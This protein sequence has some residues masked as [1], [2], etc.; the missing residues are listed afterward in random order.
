MK[1][2]ILITLLFSMN[3]LYSQNT[4]TGVRMKEFKIETNNVGELKNFEWRKVKK[5]F[6]Q[7]NKNDSIKIVLILKN[8]SKDNSNIDVQMK[9]ITSETKGQALELNKMTPRIDVQ[10]K[11]ITSEIKIKGQNFEL[12]KMIRRAK[13]MIKDMAETEKELKDMANKTNMR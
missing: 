5:F 9:R 2:L 11:S 7:N 8:D 3:F 10:M 12:N 13:K 6:N 4:K 1:K